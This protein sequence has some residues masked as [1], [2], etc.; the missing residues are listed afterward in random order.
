M[1]TLAQKMIKSADLEQIKDK[2]NSAIAEEWLAFYQYWVGAQIAHGM[3]RS[4]VEVELL[5]HANEEYAHAQ[6]LVDRLVQLGGEPANH[7][8]QWTKLARCSYET[9]SNGDTK[10]LLK[11]NIRGE[12]CAIKTYQDLMSLTADK[13]PITHKL[14]LQ[15]MEDEVVH[16]EDLEAIL[17]DM[18]A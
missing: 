17:S 3:M 12:Q 14:A 5:E 18:G 11:Q 4:V 6:L 1:G 13:D 10:T 8:E 9:P 2:L 7:P 16:E 15:I